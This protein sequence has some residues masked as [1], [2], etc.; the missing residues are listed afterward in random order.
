VGVTFA[1]VTERRRKEDEL[2]RSEA[3][4]AAGERL[5]HTGSWALNV[6]TGDLFWSQEVF[7]IF[8][9]DP[10][11]TKPSLGDTFLQRIHPEDRPKIEKGLREAPTQKESYEADYRVVVPDGSVK[12]VR[13]VVYPV[14][15]QSGEVVER[16]GVVVDV[17]ERKLAEEALRA[18]E[19]RYRLLFQ[20]TPLP[21][22]VF[23]VETLSFL[24]VNAAAV[25]HYGYSREEFLAMTAKDIRPP[26][27]V[28]LFLE[29]VK[30]MASQPAGA[31]AAGAWRH[32]TKAGTVIE[33]DVTVQPI[34]FGGRRA[35]LVVANDVTLRRQAE[36]QMQRAREAAE[37]A[38]RA[39]SDFLPNINHVPLFMRSCIALLPN[40]AKVPPRHLLTPPS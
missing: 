30:D 18:S 37:A 6:S 22:W 39:K 32:R 33:V 27:D 26:E 9:L 3:Y 23:D 40:T 34:D 31:Y 2:R 7:R 17:T 4:L 36:A 12:Y 25:E 5:S 28:G 14:T 1:D 8:G 21:M 38:N 19:E 35:E 11:T 10:A 24:A 15:S 16:Y 13:D 20:A 29:S